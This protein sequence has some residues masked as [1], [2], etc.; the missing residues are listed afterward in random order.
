MKKE[1]TLSE[2]N[3][4]F[5]DFKKDY[6]DIFARFN[7]KNLLSSYTAILHKSNINHNIKKDLFTA[8]N[9]TLDDITTIK[10][11][12]ALSLSKSQSKI[13][14]LDY[15]FVAKINELATS[16]KQ[17][18]S[19][20]RSNCKAIIT[21]SS[22]LDIIRKINSID[23]SIITYYNHCREIF[24]KLKSIHRK[25]KST[26]EHHSRQKS[27]ET[28][29]IQKIYKRTNSS[30]ELSEQSD[31]M[32]YETSPNSHGFFNTKQSFTSMMRN[33]HCN[34]DKYIFELT[35]IN[36]FYLRKC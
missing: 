20:T 23:N 21:Q 3:K 8:Y 19:K 25:N 31:Y 18:T 13:S 34:N 5:F 30:Y 22:S 24:T 4:V 2:I 14:N 17:Y 28:T 35:F 11:T 27:V 32:R 9:K 36:I 10:T 1:T 12:I 33:K 29:P 16:L 26:N 15:A 6:E 7:Y